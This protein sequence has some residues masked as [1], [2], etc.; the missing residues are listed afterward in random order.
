MNHPRSASSACGATT[1]ITILHVLIFFLLNVSESLQPPLPRDP[2]ILVLI[3]IFNA[4]LRFSHLSIFF[5]L[6]VIIFSMCP[7]LMMFLMFLLVLL[8]LLLVPPLPATALFLLRLLL[9]LLRLRHELIHLMTAL[10]QVLLSATPR[11]IRGN[12]PVV[13]IRLFLRNCTLLLF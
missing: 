4:L 6:L 10:T 13:D 7:L 11:P 9:V 2:F 1:T 3:P 12:K 8:L 5:D